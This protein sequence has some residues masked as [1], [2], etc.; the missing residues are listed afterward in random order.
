VLDGKAPYL[1][2]RD[3]VEG[4]DLG[5]VNAVGL[6]VNGGVVS[7]RVSDFDF[8]VLEPERVGAAVHHEVDGGLPAGVLGDGV[9]EFS[10]FAGYGRGGAANELHVDVGG[11]A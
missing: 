5:G 8:Q 6:V 3:A 11:R 1:P 10:G 9:L 2:A 4:N 7:S